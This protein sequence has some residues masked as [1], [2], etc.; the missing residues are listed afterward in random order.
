M[1][2]EHPLVRDA[3]PDLVTEL[4]SL[5]EEEGEGDL[6]I[7]ARD[8]RLVAMC[9]CGDDFCQSI[10]TAVHPKGEPYGEGHRCVPLLPAEGMLVLDVVHGRIMYVEVLNRAPM[11]DHRSPRN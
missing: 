10:H 7:C 1:E 6:A 8:L 3:F 5:L 4:T 2:Q 11:R 9:D